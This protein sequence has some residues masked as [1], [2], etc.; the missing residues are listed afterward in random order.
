[1]RISGLQPAAVLLLGLALFDAFGTIP[2]GEIFEDLEDLD[3]ELG[4]EIEQL[5]DREDNTDVQHRGQ[6][7]APAPEEISRAGTPDTSIPQRSATTKI[8]GTRL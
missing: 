4:F 3:P 1:M 6:A 8:S 7:T 5:L 2:A